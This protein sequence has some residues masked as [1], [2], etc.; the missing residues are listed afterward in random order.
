MEK[1]R[2]PKYESF[3][4]GCFLQETEK[5]YDELV[6]WDK[7]KRDI[8]NPSPLASV[9][10]GMGM[11]VGDLA[12]HGVVGECRQTERDKFNALYAAYKCLLA[13]MEDLLG[14]KGEWFEDN[15]NAKGECRYQVVDTKQSE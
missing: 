6:Q 8:D 11:T 14:I 7:F 10:L 4:L 9:L 1:E 12:Y 2:T 3:Q 5:L 13:T 15:L